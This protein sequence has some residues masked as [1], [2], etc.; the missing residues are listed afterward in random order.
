MKFK[1]LAIL[2]IITFFTYEFAYSHS[3]RTNSSGC[4]NVTAT[5]GYHCHGGG[6]SGGSS[7][8]SSSGDSESI[9]NDGALLI[10]GTVV[11]I[12]ICWV[13]IKDD[14]GCL[15]DTQYGANP[16]QYFFLRE[17]LSVPSSRFRLRDLKLDTEDINGWRLRAGYTFYF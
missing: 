6:S 14:T 5:G 11:L 16:I 8:R 3:G 15:L 9:F 1:L 17:Q 2:L 4:H 10:L 12:G 7:S 13:L